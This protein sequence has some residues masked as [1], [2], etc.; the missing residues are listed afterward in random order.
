MI[1]TTAHR[2]RPRFRAARRR[3]LGCCPGSSAACLAQSCLPRS[4]VWPATRESTDPNE[5]AGWRGDDRLGSGTSGERRGRHEAVGVRSPQRIGRRPDLAMAT[6]CLVLFL[7]FLDNTI[8]S[9]VLA[10]VQSDL[11]AGINEL[12][13]VVN[14][15]ALV[16]ASL[17]LTFGTLGDLFGRKKVMLCGVAVFCAGSVLAA[18][19]PNVDLLIV[20]RA[21]MGLG[22]AASEPGTLSMIR[23]LYPDRRERARALG[24]WAA[25]SGLALALGPVIGGVLAGSVVVAGG[26]LVQRLLR[27]GCHGRGPLGAPGELRPLGQAT[28]LPRVPAWRRR[29]GFGI[30]RGDRRG[31]RR[32]RS[33]VDRPALRRGDLGGGRVRPLRAAGRQSRSGGPVLPETGFQRIQL[34]GVLHVLFDLRSLLLR[35]PLSRGGGDQLVVPRLLSTSFRW[36]RASS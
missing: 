35:R 30:V 1:E 14:G 4:R 33:L 15:Y 32:V 31:D 26:L 34:R 6:L 2:P 24:V 23:H 17:M 11:H 10:N 28:R 18:L 36:R 8:V 5:R 27:L 7:T 25:V 20:G 12:Q 21:V 13:W 22:A 29:A 9:V 19:A 16:F 3:V